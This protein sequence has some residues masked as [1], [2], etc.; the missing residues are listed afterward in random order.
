[1]AV[2]TIFPIRAKNC[3][4]ILG[5]NFCSFDELKIKIPIEFLIESGMYA[6][7][8]SNQ[9]FVK[10][11]VSSGATSKHLGPLVWIIKLAKIF[12]SLLVFS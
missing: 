12:S 5:S 6:E 10:C 7:D 3:V 8:V 2:E 11:L 9:D 1:M 4:S